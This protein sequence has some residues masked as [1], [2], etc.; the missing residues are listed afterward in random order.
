MGEAQDRRYLLTEADAFHERNHASSDPATLRPRKARIAEQL[1]RGGAR[2][3]A[4]IE[5]GCA[6][7]DLL[8]HF[9][10]E[11]G[12]RAVGVEPSAKAVEMG[13]AAYGD[14][15][16]LHVGTMADNPV[17]ADPASRGAY[18]VVVVDDV[19][20]WVS[21]ETIFASVANLDALLRDG[22][23]LF[24]Q[25]FLPLRQV[26]NRNHHVSEEEVWCHKPRGPHSAMFTA[27]GAY[28]VVY[29]EVHMDGDD[30]WLRER[31][32]DPFESRWASTVLRKSFGEYFEDGGA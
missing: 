19:F 32:L 26:R 8:D 14:A 9:A 1:A 17:S 3:S 18:D 31:G 4:V 5:F 30:L 10:R 20:C 27:S 23:F 13:R 12:A 24:V 7:G 11:H 28:E 2:P 22:G 29:Q 21:R 15:V 25:E 16:E 6:Y